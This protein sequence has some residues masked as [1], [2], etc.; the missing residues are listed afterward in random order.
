MARYHHIILRMFIPIVTSK[1]YIP[2]FVSSVVFVLA[3]S[4]EAVTQK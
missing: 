3:T 2:I 1:V 4:T